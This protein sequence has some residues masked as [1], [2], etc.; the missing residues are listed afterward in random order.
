[1]RRKAS[2]KAWLPLTRV[3]TAAAGRAVSFS[4]KSSTTRPVLKSALLRKRL[5][6][7]ALLLA[8]ITLTAQNAS[9]VAI[10][11][12]P[13]HRLALENQYVRVFKVEIAPAEKTLMHR[14]EHDYIFVTLGPAEVSNEVKDK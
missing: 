3:K 12:E 11:A 4:P 9:E 7:P 1:M 6:I 10:T 8:A 5:V 2:G 14:H 13:H